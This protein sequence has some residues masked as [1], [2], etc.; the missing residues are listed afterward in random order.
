MLQLAVATLSCIQ[1]IMECMAQCHN[2]NIVI[3]SI[4]IS[5]LHWGIFL[6][7]IYVSSKEEINSTL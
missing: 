3:I 4:I 5:N 2:N 6:N 7:Y 1:G